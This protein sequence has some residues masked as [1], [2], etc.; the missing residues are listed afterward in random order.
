MSVDAVGA[1]PSPAPRAVLWDMD[2]TLVDTEPYWFSAERDLVEGFGG[3]WPE[4]HAKAIV[5]LD[6]MDAAAYI[7]EH[8]GV[9]LG[10]REIVDRMLDGVIARLARRIPWRPGARELL[11]DLNAAGVPCALV[12]MSWRRFVDPIIAA[13]P[14]HTFTAVIT[15][16]I[17]PEG[18]GKPHPTPYVMGA[19]ECG[20]APEECLAIEDSPTGVASARAAGCP[21]LGIPNVRSIRE[22]PGV[23][24]M[25]SLEG[26][27]VDDLPA[28]VTAARSA[29]R[30]RPNL[31]D[32]LAHYRPLL[33]IAAVALT[34]M[35]IGGWWTSRSDDPPPLPPGA[36]PIDLW[37]PY[38]TLDDVLAMPTERFDDVREASPFWYSVLGANEI[39]VDPNASRE[40]VAAMN[41]IVADSPARLIPS[42]ID[43][44][45]AGGMAAVLADPARRAEHVA[46]IVRF[47]EQTESDGVDIDYEQFAFADAPS[48]WGAT[49]P[50]WVAFVQELGEAL[51]ERTL[52][53]SVP[54]V[55]DVVDNG[56]GTFASSGYWVYDHGAIAEHV[57]AIRIMAYDYSVPDPGPIAPI[58]WVRNVVDGVSTVVP[59]EW[60]DRLVLG[61]PAY[62]T[63]WVVS[64]S[65]D[66][67]DS[68]EGRI[69]V[70]A[71][72]VDDLA[73]R[74][75]ATPVFDPVTD[76]WSFTYDLDV[77]DG[78]ASCVQSRRVHWVDAEGVASR[79]EVARRADWGAVALW[80]LGY[81]DDAV[82]TALVD[83][84]RRPLDAEAGSVD[85]TVA[86]S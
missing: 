15:G 57:D 31:A 74:R 18:E 49:R 69:G 82:W 77:T 52:T 32:R 70:T 1:P 72:T 13:L 65:G 40:Q 36:V 79:V 73:E 8:A 85:T 66:C 23:T 3:T 16:D 67:P 53:V 81:D 61:V 64:T 75:G 35:A 42:L 59:E 12:T 50:H 11:A 17:V 9:P 38:W 2:G 30:S 33:L 20:F 46:A 29:G 21:V 28:V 25:P 7:Q 19:E 62:G 34:L 24:V 43:K 83:A 60:H 47:V 5:G 80:A 4:H 56:D 45:P 10:R 44:M 76:E 84:A 14:D 27:G 22:G 41:E 51:G 71:R 6:L 37:T 55:W 68:A 63:N 39:V 54:G 78:A 58:E 26:L 86:G 48:T